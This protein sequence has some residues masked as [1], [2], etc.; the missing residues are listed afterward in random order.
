M[1][2]P[3]LVLFS[4]IC[5]TKLEKK[6]I[7]PQKKTKLYKRFVDDIFIRRLLKLMSLIIY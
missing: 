2:G 6:T 5:I 4:N 7:L 3:L 1:V